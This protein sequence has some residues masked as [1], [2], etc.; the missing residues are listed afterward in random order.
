MKV[1]QST[2]IR[3]VAIVG[4]GSCGKTM[5]SESMLACGGVTNRL[6]SITGTNTI[7]DYRAEEHERQISIFASLM[8]LEWLG[9]KINF[10]DNPG[11]LDFLSE[12][13]GSLRVADS[14]VIV[15]NANNGVEVGTEQVWGFSEKYELPKILVV[16]GMD[17][18][19][20]DFEGL[21]VSLKERFG[22]KVFPMTLPVNAGPGFNK[23]LDVLRKKVIT[24]SNDGMGK[25]TESDPS[26]AEADLLD[27]QHEAFIEFV[28]E[29]DDELLEKFFEEGGLT[30][31]EMRGG[32]HE[33]YKT[34]SFIPLFVTS[35]EQN[36]GVSR[37]LDFIAKYGSSPTDNPTVKGS[38]P[39]GKEVD[40]NIADASPCVYVYKTASEA[41]VGDMSFFRIY[42]GKLK[43]GDDLVN[44]STGSHERIGQI[45]AINGKNRDTV[46]ELL[47]GDIGAVVKLRDTHTGNTIVSGKSGIELEKVDYPR[48]NIHG[49]L[50]LKSK[51]DED[52]IAEGLS[53]LHEGDPTFLYRADPEIQ[54]T[55]LSG[56]GE[57]HLQVVLDQLKRRFNI[58]I[59]LIEP[60][61]PFRETI[62][63]KAESKYR[64]KKQTGG[65]GQFGEV[66]MRI[67]PKGRDEGVEFTESLVG[68]NVDRVFVP[69]VE[70]GVRAACIE[71]I[72]AG[73]HVVDVKINF[74]DGKMHPVDSK[75][76]A[77]QIAGKQAFREAF[78]KAKPRLLEPIFIVT[79]KVPDEC[80]GD[81][82][83][84]V[85]SRRG[86]V[87][88]MDAEGTFQIVKAQIPQMELYR[89]STVI[90]SLSGGRGIHAEEFSH[91]EEMPR[92]LEHKVIADALKRKQEE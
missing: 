55:V 32:V 5:L 79:I 76:V 15:I 14:S 73:Y 30:E 35:A 43:Q 72:V 69:S 82:M 28:A 20:T 8:H 4:H 71:G 47:A 60:K 18:E 85:S 25:A 91:Y 52:K 2:D 90:R 65:A 39:G 48:P 66:W 12:S 68:Q 9:K 23:I 27:E 92:E 16:N 19:H 58:E 24:Y 37:M 1:Y 56:Q 81:I 80:L 89:Y 29:A 64:H 40:V 50:R 10:I 78:K 6:G 17:R 45:Y 26:G 67:E 13:L 87:L 42:S 51:G 83:G 63:A 44:S 53:T 41:H 46:D 7:S 75:D 21:L 70:K 31:E 77:F 38:L 33:A 34:Q 11:Y 3:N 88:G 36:V 59:E 54:Q 61:V 22:N 49:A 74:Y 84:D 62:K 57:L 86:K